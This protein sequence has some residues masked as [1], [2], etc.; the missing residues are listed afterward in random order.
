[1]DSWASDIF[2]SRREKVN[3][4]NWKYKVEDNGILSK[5][6]GPVY[7]YLAK[8]I[9]QNI[10]P[11]VLTFTGLLFSLLAW[12]Y[13]ITGNNVISACCILTYMVL[14]ALDGK[15]ARNTHTS[16]S[17][18]ELVDH[19]CDC[20]SNVL[21]TDIFAWQ[22]NLLPAERYLLILATGI[23]FTTEHINSLKTG[24]VKF[25]KLTGPTE[26][27]VLFSIWIVWFNH[28]ILP[29]GWVKALIII[30]YCRIGM[31]TFEY[32]LK[33]RDYPTFFGIMFCLVIHG[34]KMNFTN[35][36]SNGFLFS[37]LCADII[38]CKMAQRP[39]NQLIPPINL[40]GVF[41]SDYAFI[42]AVGYFIVVVYDI[43]FSLK[44][45]IIMPMKRV[46]V[47]GYYDGF[48]WNHYQSLQ[49]AS[50]FGTYLIVGIHSEN[51]LIEV[52]KK[53]PIKNTADRVRDVANC[54]FVDEVIPN[55]PL[56]IN[57]KFLRDYNIHSV[58]MS[59]E[60]MKVEET[61]KIV[62][63]PFY[64]VPLD[65]GMLFVIPRG[66]GF[67]STELRT[68]DRNLMILEKLDRIKKQLDDITEKSE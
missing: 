55:C 19:F 48:H 63:D 59:D 56:T 6:L 8:F 23:L 17:L 21:L 25:G 11:N 35:P 41:F 15:H 14:D 65:L 22:Q 5:L 28:I 43:S 34:F 27:L 3:L 67:S 18:G 61:G 33:S 12:Q 62:V 30:V 38:L 58:G 60:Y 68:N 16:S 24:T 45:P 4:K 13:Y 54:P 57:E 36:I 49:K 1:M 53:V 29:E 37:T 32:Y 31:A 66:E 10:S 52:K 20:L 26:L 46:F 50:E 39:L 64:Q 2:L 9:P 40:L 7:N 47:S 51:D 44:I 42:L